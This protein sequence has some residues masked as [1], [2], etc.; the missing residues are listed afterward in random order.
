MGMKSASF[1]SAAGNR[2]QTRAS[3]GIWVAGRSETAILGLSQLQRL[4]QI[5]VELLLQLGQLQDLERRRQL[6][7]R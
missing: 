4:R 7:R 6:L 5:E 3:V 1:A 2:G